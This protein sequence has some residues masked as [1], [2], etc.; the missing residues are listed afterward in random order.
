M[1]IEDPQTA[2]KLHSP[3]SEELKD[4]LGFLMNCSESDLVE[5]WSRISSEWN[6]DSVSHVHKALCTSGRIHDLV[7]GF[8]R[9]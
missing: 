5:S 3:D 6:L 2:C 1:I 9:L 8:L 7:E 4:A